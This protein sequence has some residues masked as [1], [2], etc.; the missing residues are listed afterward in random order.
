MI[1]PRALAIV[2]LKRKI[3]LNEIKR[4]AFR[5]AEEIERLDTRL[6]QV[7]DLQ[8]AYKDHLALPGLSP[9]ELRSTVQIL[10]RL[11]ERRDV[12]GARREILET[13]RVRLA[14]M[15]AEKK[16]QIDK[17]EEE[18][19]AARRAERAEKEARREALM[20]LRRI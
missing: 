8:S 1:R 7:A 12:D 4:E 3:A 13:E 17:L 14:G 2:A 16:R 5:L 18:E 11:N 15:L 6:T 20:P 9:T 10:N 19:Q